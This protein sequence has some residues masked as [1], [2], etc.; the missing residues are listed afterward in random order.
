MD[1]GQIA[2]VERRLENWG[3][4]ARGEGGNASPNTCA[5]AERLYVPPRED[6]QRLIASAA[7]P[8]N[9][10]DA[11]KVEAAVVR[12]KRQ[13]DRKFLI[14]WY[15]YQTNPYEIARRHQIETDL[16]RANVLRLIGAVFYHLEH[17]PVVIPLAKA[18]VIE[19][20]RN[21]YAKTSPPPG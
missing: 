8:V 14:E 19:Y 9:A 2:D 11:V 20:A 15:V 4:W 6:E 5:S 7:E 16:L 17:A 21:R 13:L 18:R 10:R 3:R 1:A 12:V